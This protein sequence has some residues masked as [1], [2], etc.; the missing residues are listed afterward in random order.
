M[1]TPAYNILAVR[2]T[3]AAVH[4][5]LAEANL[6]TAIRRRIILR[7]LA[8]LRD[9]LLPVKKFAGILTRCEQAAD[10][11][12]TLELVAGLDLIASLLPHLTYGQ[13]VA[14]TA[15]RAPSGGI[16]IKRK[17]G[18]E[19]IHTSALFKHLDAGAIVGVINL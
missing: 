9:T 17:A 13:I 1:T 7:Q 6:D 2:K 12:D 18:I 14:G 10:H 5:R 3:I 16:Y 4:H 8:D 19:E 15:F 11:G